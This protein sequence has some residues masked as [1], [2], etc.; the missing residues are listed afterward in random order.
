MMTTAK[1]TSI[2][3]NTNKIENLFVRNL[4]SIL[5]DNLGILIGLA[6]LCIILAFATES[7]A[8]QRNFFNVIRQIAINLFLAS[9]MSLV[10]IYGGIDLS[11]GSVMAISGCL[12]AGF[13]SWFG[14]PWWAAIL[15]GMLGGMLIG[16]F[17]GFIV[18]MTSIAPFIVTL[19]TMNIGR[20]IARVFTN[21]KTIIIDDPSFIFIGTGSFLGLPIQ[22][23]Q[24]IIVIFLTYF[25]MG[26][27]QL[28]RHI[29]AVGDNR[30]AAS[31]SGVNVRKVSFFV[32]AYSAFLASFA[33]I[34]SA[35]RTFA[36]TMTMGD[37][38]EM[39]AIAAVVLGGVSM[40]GG[41]GRMSGVVIGCII[42]GVLKN[43]MNLV[44][45][46][47]SWQYIVQGIVILIAVLIDF[48]KKKSAK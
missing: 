3:K 40:S 38:A 25:I 27:T 23:Y 8:T 1:E 4:M 37:G 11:V 33:G 16:A 22:L 45:I 17:N 47:S 5:K 12:G 21:A 28:G 36:G 10:I 13:V 34:L 32:F 2:K 46:D 39:D 43:G 7:F 29:Y 41:V 31:Y 6:V 15:M 14:F 35:A 9:G 44:G 18:S 24:I 20:G 48:M 42:I 30:T 19:A 26:R